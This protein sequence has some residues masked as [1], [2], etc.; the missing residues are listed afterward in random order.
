MINRNQGSGTRI[1]IDR[2]LSG[3]PGDKLPQGYA[4]QAKNH[5]A[6][7]AAIRQGRADWGVAIESV[8]RVPEGGAAEVQLAFLPLVD[9]HYD[10]VVPM[11]RRQR[12]AVQAFTELLQESATR[13][14]LSALGFALAESLGS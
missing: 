2:L 3:A 1:L 6:V 5:N 7:T 4:V 10:F 14:R 13:A 11:T 12:P 9:E 8:L